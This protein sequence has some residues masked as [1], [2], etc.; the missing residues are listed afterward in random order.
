M[1]YNNEKYCKELGLIPIKKIFVYTDV[2]YSYLCKIDFNSEY[3]IKIEY[4]ITIECGK[5]IE[6]PIYKIISLKRS[7]P[8]SLSYN[9]HHF[10][11]QLYMNGKR[12]Y[13]KESG[14]KNYLKYINKRIDNKGDL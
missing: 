10:C 14:I 7:K 8:E 5:T 6:Y 4:E 2:D 3:G 12:Y 1:K 13:L 11:Y 9:E